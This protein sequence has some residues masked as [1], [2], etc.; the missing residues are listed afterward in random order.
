MKKRKFKPGDVCYVVEGSK[1]TRAEISDESDKEQ[2]LDF[3]E[4]DKYHAVSFDGILCAIIKERVFHTQKEAENC[5]LKNK[6]EKI[7]KLVKNYDCFAMKFRAKKKMTIAMVDASEDYGISFA[8][9]IDE[10]VG[11]D[12]DN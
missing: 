10:F 5:I 8:D 9:Y 6:R 4:F 11:D 7:V 2:I 1:V 12:S 3:D